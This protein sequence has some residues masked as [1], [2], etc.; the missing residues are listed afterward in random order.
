MIARR[1]AMILPTGLVIGMVASVAQVQPGAPAPASAPCV[2]AE[3]R[4]FDFWVGSWEVTDRS[5]KPAGRNQITREQLDCVLVERWTSPNGGTGMSMNYYD[6]QS[7]RWTQHWV[8]LGLILTMTGGLRGNE[9]VL[10][11]PLQYVRDGRV[12][13]LRGTWTSLPDGRVRQ[14]FVESSDGG[15]TWSEWFDGYYRKEAVSPLRTDR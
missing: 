6:P 9:M 1:I 10:E 13:I 8:G 2:A 5:G 3:F 15:K 11:G 14:H 4:Q 7:R 12:T